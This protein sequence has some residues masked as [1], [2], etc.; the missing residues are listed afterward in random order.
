VA[1]L[2]KLKLKYS[3]Y[4]SRKVQVLLTQ[5]CQFMLKNR[6]TFP[7]NLASSPG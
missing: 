5:N 1:N 2:L 3:F 6:F 7:K 4:I